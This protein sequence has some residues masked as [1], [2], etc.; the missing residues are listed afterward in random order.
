MNILVVGTKSIEQSLINV[1]KNSKLLDR[2][3]TASFAP[4]DSIPNIEYSDPQDLV[5][6]IR[7][8]QI[9]LVLISDKKL[10]KEGLVDILRKNLINVISVNQKWFNLEESRIVA[11]QLMNYYSINTPQLIKAP[12]SFPV[13]IK[14]NKPLL[15]KIAYTMDEL[16]Y[17]REQIAGMQI[18]L[19]EYLDG[20]LYYLLSL[21]DGKNLLFFNMHNTLTEV[22]EDRLELLKTKLCIMFA[23]ETP[24][25]IGFFTTK[26]IWA[27]NDWHVLEYI[28]KIDNN[29]NLNVIEQDFLFILNAAIYQKLDEI[30]IN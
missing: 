23:D 24:D 19:E 29:H 10:I 8:L 3:Y 28:M 9:D 16:V 22:Q 12:K 5:R 25:F 1:C 14:T 26:L 11:K 30:K 13:V 6:K 7:A 2:I 20:D 27:N 15:T 21:W 18:F 4:L 17:Y